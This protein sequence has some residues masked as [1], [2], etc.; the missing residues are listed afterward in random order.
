MKGGSKCGPSQH[1]IS[2][3]I[4][5]LS[6]EPL[7]SRLR[8]K[9]PVAMATL[10]ATS[11]KISCGRRQV[12]VRLATPLPAGALFFPPLVSTAKT[13]NSDSGVLE[14]R[15]AS[16]SV[17]SDW[18]H[19]FCVLP[20]MLAR[21]GNA[22]LP[23]SYRPMSARC[24]DI[25]MH[26]PD[27]LPVEG[28]Y[29]CCP[30]RNNFLQFLAG[31]L[32]LRLAHAIITAC[33]GK[34][35]TRPV[36]ESCA[37]N[38]RTDSPRSKEPSRRFASG[39][40]GGV[41]V[42]PFTSNLCEQGPIP[43]VVAPKFSHPDDTASPYSPY[44]TLIGS[45]EL[46]IMSRPNFSTPAFPQQLNTKS[47][48]NISGVAP[49][50]SHLR[51]VPDDTA[52]R[53]FFSGISHFLHPFIPA[54]LHTHLTSPSSALKTSIL[55]AAVSVEGK[56]AMLWTG[57]TLSSVANHAFLWKRV[58]DIPEF[59]A[60]KIFER[61]VAA[62]SWGP[63]KVIE[64]SMER[65]RNEGEGGNG[66]C[67]KWEQCRYS[68]AGETGNPREKPADQSASSGTIPTCENPE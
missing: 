61:L 7:R 28:N 26:V 24:L 35:N 31:V 63:M 55:F 20:F 22:T 8:S 1:R 42:R 14:Q 21:R 56:R 60:F 40:R 5:V 34:E 29:C 18:T 19:P 49:G 27:C 10:R 32:K 33:R 25:S 3:S 44:I 38:Q 64:V 51:I 46:G 16:R 48:T 11:G 62:R 58:I 9:P 65:R 4:E 23:A 53:R 36:P 66:R 57:D 68:R 43:G 45:Q 54:L 15:L 47:A 12:C 17:A 6:E 52:G 2:T 13:P 41:V 59:G 30:F 67:P 50:F 37:T 39:G